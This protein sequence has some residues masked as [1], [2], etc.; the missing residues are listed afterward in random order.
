MK[1]HG[2]RRRGEYLKEVKQIKNQNLQK[3]KQPIK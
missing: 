3:T 1:N 2:S